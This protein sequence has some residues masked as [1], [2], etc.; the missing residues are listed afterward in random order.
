MKHT[1]PNQVRIPALGYLYGGMN[2]ILTPFAPCRGSPR[3]VRC[4]Y[5]EG[6]FLF[7]LDPS[8]KSWLP[9]ERWH[10]GAASSV[11]KHTNDVQLKMEKVLSLKFQQHP[12][13]RKELLDTGDA[14]LVEV[15]SSFI[16]SL[17]LVSSTRPSVRTRTPTPS[18]E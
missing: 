8:Y 4:Q 5:Q 9:V 14:L 13:L 15:R 3:L 6:T 1:A 17:S 7:R 11:S 18:G 12:S 10:Q 2:G 16:L